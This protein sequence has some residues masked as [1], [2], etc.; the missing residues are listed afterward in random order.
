MKYEFFMGSYFIN[1]HYI[2][3]SLSVIS[4]LQLVKKHLNVFNAANMTCTMIMTVG[5]S[6]HLPVWLTNQ[7]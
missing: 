1:F 7:H 4:K 2:F 3:M 6:G 5:I